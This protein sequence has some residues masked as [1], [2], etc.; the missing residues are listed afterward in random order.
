MLSVEVSESSSTTQ[1]A[2]RIFMALRVHL[3][4]YSLTERETEIVLL[5]LRGM[6]N[7]EI[8]RSCSIREQTVK[9]H[10]KHAY[11]KVGVHQRSALHATVLRNIFETPSL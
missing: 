5:V 6:S 4:K 11:G 7:K 10:L 1:H 2:A 8:A 3:E 9:D